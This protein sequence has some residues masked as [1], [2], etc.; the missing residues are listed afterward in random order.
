MRPVTHFKL[1]GVRL[2]VVV[3][4]LYWVAIFTGTHLPDVLDFSPR[5]YDKAKHFAAFFGL[6]TLLCYVTNSRRLILRFTMVALVCLTYAASDEVTQ[7][8]V[9]GRVADFHDF[10][11]DA[12][13]GGCAIAV[14]VSLRLVMESNRKVLGPT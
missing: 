1:F 4:T 2:G 13:G 9:V 8:F 12:L 3:L 5:I 7:S 6:T 11:A 10:L 14:Y